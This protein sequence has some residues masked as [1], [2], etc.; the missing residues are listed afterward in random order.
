MYDR[1]IVPVKEGATVDSLEQ[2]RLFARSLGCD[3][4]LL[5]V[6]RP[7][8]VPEGLDGLP[9]YRYQHVVESWSGR[10]RDAEAREVE[11]LAELA[12]GVAALDPELDVAHRVVHAP[13]SRC[14]G[15]ETERVLAV[16]SEG[17]PEGDGLDPTAQELIRTCGIPVLLVRPE[18]AKLTIRRILVAL[19]G[20]TFSEE[21]LAPAMELARSAGA[22]LTLLEVVTRHSGLVRFLY[23]VER[24]AETAERSLREVADRLPPELGPVEVRVAE[25]ASA[26]AGILDEAKRA[27]A[28]LVAMATHGRGGIA[29]FLLGSVAE[30]VVQSSPVPVLVFRPRG[31]GSQAPDE[32][33]VASSQA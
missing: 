23:P 29:R 4:T 15:A 19:D 18:M 21:A 13:L 2:V 31:V 22:S 1:I 30:R 6:H 9:Q 26:A 5:H 16:V 28:D 7:R 24:S 8:E 17:D 32:Q 11:W 10:D 12:N 25:N 20:S 14:V 3:L 33:G 27:G